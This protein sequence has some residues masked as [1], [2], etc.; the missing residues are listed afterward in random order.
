MMSNIRKIV[1][2]NNKMKTTGMTLRVRIG[3]II[4]RIKRNLH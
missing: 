1:A 2:M 3:I 4:E